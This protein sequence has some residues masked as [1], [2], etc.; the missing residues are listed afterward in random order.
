MSPDRERV[1][2][3]DYRQLPTGWERKMP[4]G[5]IKQA[6]WRENPA[7]ARELLEQLDMAEEGRDG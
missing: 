4:D 1:Y 7:W 3:D 2:H 5:T 6:H